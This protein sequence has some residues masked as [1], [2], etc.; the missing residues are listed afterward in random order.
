[1][2]RRCHI[3]VVL[4]IYQKMEGNLY[5][6]SSYFSNKRIFRLPTC[7]ANY[8][9]TD[10]KKERIFFSSSSHCVGLGYRV[11]HV[12]L[13]FSLRER[14][15]G[16]YRSWGPHAEKRVSWPRE[17]AAATDHRLRGTLLNF[18]IFAARFFFNDVSSFLLQ[19]HFSKLLC[20]SSWLDHLTSIQAVGSLFWWK[21]GITWKVEWRALDVRYLP[22]ALDSLVGTV[23]CVGV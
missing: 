16:P 5:K 12:T 17:T 20:R 19:S 21:E 10:L 8:W 4:Y 22:G 11:L 18:N 3:F 23:D 15:I 1:M 14:S 6:V 7:P 2:D 13:P 9:L